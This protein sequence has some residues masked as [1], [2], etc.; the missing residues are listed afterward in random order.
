MGSGCQHA[1]HKDLDSCYR[2]NPRLGFQC[3]GNQKENRDMSGPYCPN[4]PKP[5]DIFKKKKKQFF[6][7]NRALLITQQEEKNTFYTI[8]QI[9]GTTGYSHSVLRNILSINV[10]VIKS[11]HFY[12][13]PQ[14]NTY[15]VSIERRHQG[16]G[17]S[18]VKK[19]K[20]NPTDSPPRS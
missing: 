11:G 17:T 15:I 12:R 13:G 1:S 3:P 4:R 7:R 20:N 14:W 8:F 9:G 2:V 19:E 10:E 6:K 18:A 16:N 5:Q